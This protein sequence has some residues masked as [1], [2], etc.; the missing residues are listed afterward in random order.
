MSAIYEE[1]EDFCANSTGVSQHSRKA[2]NRM[3]MSLDNGFA[4]GDSLMDEDPF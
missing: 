2:S 3:F 1:S 4:H